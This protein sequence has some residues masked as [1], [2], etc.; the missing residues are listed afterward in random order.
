MRAPVASS[1]TTAVS[2]A[3]LSLGLALAFWPQPGRT[4][5]DRDYM[6]ADTDGHLVIRFVGIGPDG[7]DPVQADEVLDQEFSTMIH[8]RLRADLL[9]EAEP[10]DPDWAAS[11]EPQIEQ[12]VRQAGPEFSGIFVEC[13]AVSCR[14]LMQQ[15]G[16]WSVQAQR[17][18]LAA[19]QASLQTFI[20]A[21]RPEFEPVFMLTAYDQET[22]T[23]HIKAFLR[24]TGRTFT[25]RVDR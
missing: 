12:Q 23:A 4:Q 5:S 6:F 10:R 9:F 15:P 8:D 1:V 25:H 14:V 11:M 18:V 17:P 20:E 19:V 21:H 7:L 16:D 22:E 24:R 13:R 3:V 2:T